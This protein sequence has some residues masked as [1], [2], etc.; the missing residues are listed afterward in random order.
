[1]KNINDEIYFGNQ[2]PSF[3]LKDLY[4]DNKIEKEKYPAR[5]MTQ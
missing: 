4:N 3:L 2:N 5:L 1:M